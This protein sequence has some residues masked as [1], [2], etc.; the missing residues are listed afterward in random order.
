MKKVLLSAIATLTLC[1]SVS[2]QTTVT[3]TATG[4]AGSF[5][6]G[7]VNNAGVKNDG[8]MVSISTASNAGWAK[9]DMTAI[10]AGAVVMSVNCA[11]TTFTS[12]TSG[13][14]NNLYG[15]IG[16]QL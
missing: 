7:S 10:P 11:F 12:T 1:F 16:D 6:T 13:A 5:N 3:I 15:F 9:F 4:T 8:N 14:T 2:A